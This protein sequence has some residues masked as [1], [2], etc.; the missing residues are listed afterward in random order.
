MCFKNRNWDDILQALSFEKGRGG[1][2]RDSL[3]VRRPTLAFGP[4][5]TKL[6]YAAGGLVKNVLMS[7]VGE[8][9][10]PLERPAY[11][12][13]TNTMQIHYGPGPSSGSFHWLQWEL[14]QVL[15]IQPAATTICACQAL[16]C[17]LDDLDV[18]L[19]LAYWM[20]AC[21]SF[22]FHMHEF[23]LLQN[24]ANKPDLLCKM[25]WDPQ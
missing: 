8:N 14:G 25:L 21:K 7:V 9:I 22:Y 4:F 12:V 16:D 1:G 5:W 17:D 15:C 3:C 24:G 18:F 2:D 10:Y 23:S 20:I 6:L 11:P 19:A 13:S